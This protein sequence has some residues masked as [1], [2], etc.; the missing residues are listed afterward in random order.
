MPSSST[1]RATTTSGASS[2]NREG[3]MGRVDVA[4]TS[5]MYPLHRIVGNIDAERLD[6]AVEGFAIDLEEARRR[7]DGFPP[8]LQRLA[9]DLPLRL[10]AQLAVG[11][12]ADAGH[13]SGGLRRRGEQ[14]GRVRVDGDRS[15]VV[16]QMQPLGEVA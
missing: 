16:Q 3:R 5:G 12:H 13:G 14:R 7:G 8:P 1:S 4:A 10:V 9:Q 11:K 15:R 6:T 2:R